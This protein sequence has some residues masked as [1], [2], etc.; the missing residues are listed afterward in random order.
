M[1]VSE[2]IRA[3]LATSMT[4]PEGATVRDDAKQMLAKMF[5]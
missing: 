5:R 1:L 4:T 2:G 3:V